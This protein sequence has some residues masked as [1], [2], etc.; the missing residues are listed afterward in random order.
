MDDH[1]GYVEVF[2]QRPDFSK[3]LRYRQSYSDLNLRHCFERLP[4]DRELPWARMD[5]AKQLVDRQQL[6]SQIAK[7][8]TNFILKTLE[9]DDTINGYEPED[10]HKMH[11]PKQD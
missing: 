2:I 5:G 9:S 7:E 1:L 3:P 6:A 11:N 8:L 10:W 4:R